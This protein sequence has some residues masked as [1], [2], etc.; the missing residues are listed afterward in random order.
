MNDSCREGSCIFLDFVTCKNIYFTHFTEDFVK[1]VHPVG[2]KYFIVIEASF[3]SEDNFWPENLVDTSNTIG[4]AL[5]LESYFTFYL[6]Q[7]KRTIK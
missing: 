1:A 3:R 5:I 6:F 4:F 2:I 7:V